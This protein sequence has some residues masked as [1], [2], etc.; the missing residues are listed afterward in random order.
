MRAE[1][2][3]MRQN[4]IGKL[5]NVTDFIYNPVKRRAKDHTLALV[6]RLRVDDNA[7]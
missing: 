7:K 4:F 1:R 6:P 2:G 5:Q 3:K